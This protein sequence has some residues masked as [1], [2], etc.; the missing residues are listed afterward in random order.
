MFFYFETLKSAACGG[1]RERFKVMTVVGGL[2][3]WSPTANS[4]QR[5]EWSSVLFQTP[6]TDS[7]HL[8]DVSVVDGTNCFEVL[9]SLS[10]ND[11][12]AAINCASSTQ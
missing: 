1:V 10:V 4:E 3:T 8:A 5:L 9:S 6:S 11:E 12:Q 2:S 7:W